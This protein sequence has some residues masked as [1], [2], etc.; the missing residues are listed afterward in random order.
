MDARSVL[1]ADS[2]RAFA[3]FAESQN[4]TK[5][6][7][8]LQL[9]Q[10]SLHAKIGNLSRSLGV[11]LYER[12]G[13]RLSLTEH[14]R[15][16]SAFAADHLRAVDDFL[17]ELGD[18]SGTELTVAAGRGA[19]LWV[20]GERLR[21]IGGT[22]RTVRLLT[23]DRAGSLRAVDTGTADVAVIGYDPPPGHLQSRELASYPQV[24]VLPRGHRL[25]HRSGVV[26]RDL[27]GERLIVP[28]EGRPQRQQISRALE[29]ARVH[30][31]VAVEANGWELMVQFVSLGMGVAVVNGCV[32]MPPETVAVPVEDLPPVRYWAAWRSARSAR[33]ARFVDMDEEPL[34]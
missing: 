19:Y 5:A 15:R 32:P 14:G 4:F 22:S 21:R 3:V 30:C 25:T 12:V 27:H 28:A 1:T 20:L 29:A 26:L 23:A 7:A 9:A 18:P 10:P 24:L 31:T 33:A 2:L 34:R 11:P 13:R 6:A 16:L 8:T 17:A